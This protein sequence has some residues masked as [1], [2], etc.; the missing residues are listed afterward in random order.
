MTQIP[1]LSP[2]IIF[3]FYPHPN[4]CLLISE[5]EEERERVKHRCERETWIGCLPTH[6]DWRS[7]PQPRY[8]PWQG[9]QPATF[10]GTDNTPTNWA[11]PTGHY[12]LYYVIL[13]LKTAFVLSKMDVNL[14]DCRSYLPYVVPSGGWLFPKVCQMTYTILIWECSKMWHR[15]Q[16]CIKKCSQYQRN[17]YYLLKDTYLKRELFSGKGKQ[18]I[19]VLEWSQ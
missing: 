13:Q 8:E 3:F 5:R 7:N 18:K 12:L 16:N 2:V 6:P 15:F 1:W 9:I 11:N 17:F 14:S 19:L 4:I 10:W